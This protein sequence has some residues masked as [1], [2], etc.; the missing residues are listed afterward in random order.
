M[1]V[2]PN[3]TISYFSEASNYF[4]WNNIWICLYWKRVNIFLK[5]FFLNGPDLRWPNPLAC[6]PFTRAC[7][8]PSVSHDRSPLPNPSCLH[9]PPH[10][11]RVPSHHESRLEHS[12]DAA[13][14]SDHWS[15]YLACHAC[16][17]FGTGDVVMRS[18][19]PRVRSHAPGWPLCHDTPPSPLGQSHRPN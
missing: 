16:V 15:A 3:V 8:T 11:V 17:A 6:H 5:S 19:S 4:F 13:P 9:R 12:D 18:C 7:T 10:P 1:K 14:S 2:A